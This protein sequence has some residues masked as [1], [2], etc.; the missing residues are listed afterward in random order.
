[1]AEFDYDMFVIG[2]GSGGV[3]AA[4]F[5]ANFGAKVGAAE[6]CYMGGTCVNVGC[7]PKKLFVYASHFSH[8]FEDAAAYGWT[9]GEPQF[10]WKSLRDNKDT[11]IK[12]LNGIYEN[13]LANANVDVFNARA[14]VVDPHTADVGGQKVTAKYI[15]VATGGWPVVP[16]IP[17]KEHA[18]TSNEFFHMEKWPERAIVVGGGYIAVEL[19]GVLH[20]LGTK[21]TQLYR[22]LHF[23][24]GFDDDVR[25]HLADEMRKQG[26]DLRFNANVARIDKDGDEL[27]VDFED[28]TQMRTDVVLYA[29]GRAPNSRGIGLEEA[30]VELGKNG[31]IQVDESFQTSVPSIYAIGDVIDRVQLTPVALEE[32]MAVANTLFNEKSG[33]VDY[34]NIPTAVFSQPNIGTVGLTEAQARDKHGKVDIYISDF[35]ALKH[36]LTGRD[37]RTLMKLIVHPE[38]DAVL[39]VHMVGPEAGEIIQG[40]GIALKA[41]ATKATFDATIGIHPTSAE[42]FV[43]MREK[44]PDEDR[45]AAE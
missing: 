41:G 39:G 21:V 5:A 30:G 22:G 12:R 35:K 8:D 24:R 40:I 3:R 9:V 6:D 45:R 23:L 34:T 43:T 17:G 13:M 27:V 42:E 4:R 14:T 31:A 36:T 32:G 2:I 33:P 20:G 38:T 10:D 15:L 1:M 26:I 25:Y 44:V 7:I 11:E 28:G 37:E 16:D 29:T 18:I 19:T